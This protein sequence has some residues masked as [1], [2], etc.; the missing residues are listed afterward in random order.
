[1]YKKKI[2]IINYVMLRQLLMIFFVGAMGGVVSVYIPPAIPFVLVAVVVGLI[3][4]KVLFGAII[5]P[6]SLMAV[7]W[8]LP[9]ITT[10]GEPQWR[11]SFVGWAAVLGSFFSF[12]TGLALSRLFQQKAVSQSRNGNSKDKNFLG[13]LFR[14]VFFIGL[15][16]FAI[17]FSRLVNSGGLRVYLEEGFRTAEFYFAYGWS[18][19]LYYF[20]ILV[21]ALGVLYYQLTERKIYLISSVLAIIF[22]LFQGIRTTTVVT[23]VLMFWS[24]VLSKKRFNFRLAIVVLFITILVFQLVSIGRDIHIKHTF[25]FIDLLTYKPLQLLRYI[26]PNYANLQLEILE[27]RKFL[28]GMDTFDPFVDWYLTLVEGK[29][30]DRH[31]W[32]TYLVDRR[33]NVGTYLRDFYRDFSWIGIL[34][35]PVMLGWISGVAFFRYQKR[36]TVLV[37]IINSFLFTMISF[38]FWYNFFVWKQF[39]VLLIMVL[40]VSFVSKLLWKMRSANIKG[41]QN[42]TI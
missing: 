32:N 21:P 5:N 33:Y 1:M 17:N 10:Y 38:S 25:S 41:H 22:T 35:A 14:V 37:I 31:V 9:A 3:V 6:A 18:N 28:W 11:L 24:Y 12:L 2:K 34:V 7:F 27:R 13:F 40:L 4:G 16:G 26:A 30:L 42:V 23:L 36:A 29:N 8:L 39:I 19:Y 15:I 20:N